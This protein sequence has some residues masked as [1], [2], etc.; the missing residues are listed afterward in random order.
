MPVYCKHCERKDSRAWVP[1]GHFKSTE[2][3]MI[4]RQ[5]LNNLAIPTL[6]SS[7]ISSKS[8]GHTAKPFGTLLWIPELVIFSLFPIKILL[9][10]SS[11]SWLHSWVS[12]KPRA[13]YTQYHQQLR[14][15]RKIQV[16]KGSREKMTLDP[17]NEEGSRSNQ[18]EKRREG[19]GGRQNSVCTDCYTGRICSVWQ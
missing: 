13:W 19:L 9:T 4:D 11:S 16:R 14:E 7:I 5:L 8:G 15:H 1:I 12:V 3:L 17:F 10:S 2:P 18:E 6:C